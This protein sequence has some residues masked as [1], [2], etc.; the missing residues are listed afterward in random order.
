MNIDGGWIKLHRKLL[1]GRIFQDPALLKVWVWCL[2]KANHCE[3]WVPVRTGRGDT[4]ILVKRGEFLF[5]RNSAGIELDMPATTVRDRMRVLCTHDAIALKPVTHFSIVTIINYDSYQDTIEE[6]PPTIRQPSA[7]Q[8]PQTRT[9]RTKRINTY[10]AI[11]NAFYAAYP[12]KR[13]PDR[14]WRAWEKRNGDRPEIDVILEAIKNQKLWR[15]NA[16]GK[17]RPEWKDPA[18]WINAGSWKDEVEIE[19]S[20]PESRW[21]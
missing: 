1:E 7:T 8:P 13:D 6:A 17:F 4:T 2:L 11:F 10:S 3:S 16:G 14:A 9:L 12:K 20:G 5:G 19:Q 21:K 18:T 15:E